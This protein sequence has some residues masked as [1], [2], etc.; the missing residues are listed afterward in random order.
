[1][2]LPAASTRQVRPLLETAAQ[3]GAS[4]EEGEKARRV[5]A[6]G[7]GDGGERHQVVP[8]AAGVDR[9]VG[10]GFHVSARCGARRHAAAGAGPGD[11]GLAVEGEFPAQ[12]RGLDAMMEFESLIGAPAGHGMA[13]GRRIV[14]VPEGTATAMS[15]WRLV[16]APFMWPMR[17]SRAGLAARSRA[18]QVGLR[19][20]SERPF[21]G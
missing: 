11:H 15:A 17:K 13:A 4:F 9:Q 6:P 5:Q 20:R 18:A 14:A 8:E 19:L 1:M 12:E 3:K 2:R 7:I 10:R 16:Q 21:R